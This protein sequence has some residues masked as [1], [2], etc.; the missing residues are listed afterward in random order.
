MK[1]D[2]VGESRPKGIESMRLDFRAVPV[3][4]PIGLGCLSRLA[5]CLGQAKATCPTNG[6]ANLTQ[7]DLDQVTFAVD[8]GTLRC[9]RLG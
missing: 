6:I 7:S 9:E 5:R 1:E 3:R 4:G 8:L 2:V